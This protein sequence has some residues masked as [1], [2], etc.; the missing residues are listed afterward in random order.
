MTVLS[1]RSNTHHKKASLPLIFTVCVVIFLTSCGPVPTSPPIPTT[2]LTSQPISLTLTISPTITLFPT[3]TPYVITA[4][5]QTEQPQVDLVGTFFFSL[6]DSGHYHLYGYSPD[7]MPLTRLTSK[8]SD[9]ITPAISPD[10]RML[11]FASKSNGYWDLEILDFTTGIITRLTDTLEYD[12]AP[13]WSPDGAYLSYESYQNGN[14]DIFVRSVTD[15]SQV[16]ILTQDP[17]SDFSPVWSPRGR[18]IAFVSNRTGDPEIWIAN[19]DQSGDDRFVNIS[20]SSKSAEA[21]PSWSPDGNQLAW[22]S[23]DLESGM[24]GVYLWDSREPKT[25]AHW[26]VAGDW[27]AWQNDGTIGTLLTTLN[28]TYLASYKVSG[29]V[30]LPPVQI[31]GSCLGFSFG[32][33]SIQLV[34]E[35]ADNSKLP[36]TSLYDSTITPQPATLPNRFSLVSIKGVQA[37][38]PKLNELAY[39]SYEAL[40][41]KVSIE[42]GWDALASL[43]N[44]FVPLT[45]SLEPGMGD[46]WLYTGRAVTLNPALIQANWMVVIREDFNQQTFWR[47]YLRTTAQDGSQGMPLTRTPWDF[48]ARTG[49]PVAYENGGRLASVIPSGYWFDLTACA[50]QYGWER[51]PALPT[52]RTYYSGAHF[53]EMAFIQELDW[54]TAMLQIYPIEALITPTVVIP[55]TRTPTITSMWYRSPTPTT[56]PT[57]RPTNTP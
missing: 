11:A 4:T 46:D 21:H 1:I 10:G 39:N 25:P 29:I 42:T 36:T 19:L 9:D 44:A 51:L 38:F 49:D 3:Q 50:L 18:E 45:S 27:P 28:M 23:T 32:N 33:T 54:R 2:I 35:H 34:S 56:T 24:T 47:I 41:K 5:P 14:L 17:S 8:T 16:F 55:P 40:R 22:A 48:N 6:L 37:R 26:V 52:W 13:S 12:A 43:E 15:P 31:P 57:N 53:N 30:G 7:S 20:R